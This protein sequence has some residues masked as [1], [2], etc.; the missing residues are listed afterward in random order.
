MEYS[1]CTTNINTSWV[2][3]YN[4]HEMWEDTKSKISCLE[5]CALWYP[6]YLQKYESA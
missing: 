1:I 5:T 6:D 3:S 2:L 4:T